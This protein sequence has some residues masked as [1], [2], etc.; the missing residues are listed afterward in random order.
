MNELI[1]DIIGWIGSFLLV[2]AYWLISKG[3]LKSTTAAYQL[4]NIV[5]SIMLLVNAY[6]YRAYPSS[7]V[8]VVWTF[9]GLYWLIKIS[10][11]KKMSTE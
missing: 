11:K 9:I 8:N 7:A 4:L 1:I 3:R 6:Y 2:L 5:G 10:G